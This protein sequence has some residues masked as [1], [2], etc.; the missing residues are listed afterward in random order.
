[1]VSCDACHDTGFSHGSLAPRHAPQPCPRGCKPMVLAAPVHLVLFQVSPAAWTVE[2]NICG[3]LRY[4][5]ALCETR[6]AAFHAAVEWIEQ[7]AVSA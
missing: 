3:V 1:M 6:R 7:H 5:K 2:V 4:V